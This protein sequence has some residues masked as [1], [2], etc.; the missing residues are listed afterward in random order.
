MILLQKSLDIFF[1]AL[2]CW[3]EARGED[4]KTKCAIIGVMQNRADMKWAGRSTVQDIV[5]QPWQFSGMTAKGDPNLVKFPKAGDQAWKDCLD[6]AESILGDGGIDL[7]RGAVFYHDVSIPGP[8]TAWG[9]VE[10][11]VQLGRIVFYRLK[12]KEAKAA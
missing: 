12:G 6:A 4:F 8:P 10:K 5:C 3:R 2:C 11:T 7:S 1:A 9:P